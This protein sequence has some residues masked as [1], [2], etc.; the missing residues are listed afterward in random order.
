MEKL[1]VE[2]LC[3]KYGKSRSLIEL[4]L[5][6]SVNDGYNLNESTSLINE[7]YKT[8]DDKR[9]QSGWKYSPKI[10]FVKPFGRFCYFDRRYFY[11]V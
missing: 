9:V 7:F 5:K 4:M 8:S 11:Q 6:I 1:I 3:D 10:N 2:N